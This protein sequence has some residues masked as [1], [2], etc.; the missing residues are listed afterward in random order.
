MVDPDTVGTSTLS[1]S[2]W[3][4]DA[5]DYNARPLE[6]P[7][8]DLSRDLNQR[9][10]SDHLKDVVQQVAVELS[11]VRSRMDQIEVRNKVWFENERESR[12]D[13]GRMPSIHDS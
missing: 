2:E 7:L 3:G 13:S 5:E 4:G 12:A 10:L 1:S 9:K 8:R 6:A 11:N